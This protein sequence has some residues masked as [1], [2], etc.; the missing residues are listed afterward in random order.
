[1]A[2]LEVLESKLDDVAQDVTEIKALLE[3]QN[4]RIANNERCIGVLEERDKAISEKQSV[5]SFLLTL[6]GSG[7]AAVI[8][9]Q[10]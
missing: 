4:S 7:I 6:A 1:M 5:I 2:S 9:M 3:K 10:R 8:G